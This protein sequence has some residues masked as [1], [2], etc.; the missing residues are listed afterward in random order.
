M[1]DDPAPPSASREDDG[2]I[3]G[4]EDLYRVIFD[5]SP[6]LV[7]VHDLD[8]RFLD[9]NAR[10]LERLGYTR[11]ALG[12]ITFSDILCAE[13]VPRALESARRIIED[14]AVDEIEQ[15]RIRTRDDEEIWVETSG[16]RLLKE[17]KPYAILG[18]AHDITD[19][20]Q[21]EQALRDERDR[22]QQ[23]LDVADVIFIAISIDGD[24][25]M[26]N[27]KGCELLG[28]R[29]EEVVGKN[30]FENFVTQEVRD[31]IIPV[32]RKLQTGDLDAAEYHE[33]TVLTR[34]GEERL[35]AWH[36]TVLRDANGNICAYL[37]SGEDITDRKWAEEMFGIQRDL[38]V[39]LNAV[40]D[41]DKGLRLCL[42]AA[43]QVSEMDC[44]GV[45]L[46]DEATGGLDLACSAGLSP[47]FSEHI[48]HYDAAQ[49]STAIVM[50]GGPVYASYRELNIPMDDPRLREGLRAI[51]VL[52][53]HH[54]GRVIACLNIASHVV[55]EVGERYRTSLE[56]IAGQIGGAIA[57]LR[58]KEALGE[59]ERRYRL[60]FEQSNDAVFVHDTEGR[61]LD[62]NARASEMLGY[63]RQQLL[64]M[65]VQDLHP[66][67]NREKA[68]G[69]LQKV[70]AEG[71]VKFDAAFSRSDGTIIDVEISSSVID[72]SR[73]IVQGIAR[74][75]TD[76]ES[77]RSEI[78][79]LAR[80]TSE[81]PSPVLRVSSDGII[82]HANP[83]SRPL[84]D[85]WRAGTGVR[86]PDCIAASVAESYRG[87]VSL[88]T[89]V[90]AGDRTYSFVLAPVPGEDYVNL[91]GRDITEHKR[92]QEEHLHTQ[93]ME[94]I[95]LLAGGI[96]HDFSNL[97]QGILGYAN[98]LKRQF[99]GEKRVFKA[100]DII[101]K[102]GT[103]AAELTQQLLGFAR[104]GK[105]RDT[106]VDI[107]RAIS[108]TV[109]LLSST[110]DKR[111]ILLQ[112]LNADQCI[113]KGDPGQLQQVIMN[114]A[115]NARDAMPE[116]GELSFET[117]L[118]ELAEGS[119]VLPANAPGGRY[120]RVS[121]NDTGV[122]IAHNVR[123]RVFEPFFTT[124]P[125]GKGT[126]MGLAMVYGIV[127][128]H[129][130]AIEVRSDPG[131]GTTF[132]ILLPLAEKGARAK[133]ARKL[134]VIPHGS[135]CILV[136]DDEEIVRA[137]LREMLTSLG[138][139]VRLA[140]NGRD[141]VELYRERSA[142]I[143]LVL[144]DLTMPVM[145]GRECFDELRKVDPEVKVVI[146]TGHALD[147]MAQDMMETGALR[148][149]H[150]PFLKPE[151]AET[152]AKAL[153]D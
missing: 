92:L 135:G 145:N 64:S 114:L 142:D 4:E 67:H 141:A 89:E 83:A 73:G 148:F 23:Y 57:G 37:S 65:S 8:G 88:E 98:M 66:A 71:H 7:Y 144:L 96:A 150:K 33:N 62:A 70:A 152:I 124:K 5:N 125:L 46:V 107:H 53:V 94:A 14:G 93:K 127:R 123:E 113:V 77:A 101:E 153:A 25:M 118:V 128:N 34:G 35:I 27:R 68:R 133:D 132:D 86:I 121:V 12:A 82:L 134:Q 110:I 55:W 104:R 69:S 54:D 106:P 58:A 13:D 56:T 43:L 30:W 138:Y 120:V 29:E 63:D 75:I 90:E 21:A 18:F 19:R 28:Y 38:A 60:I 50:R 139:D 147:G 10:A 140:S 76:R 91:Y 80:F 129:G 100:A 36:N 6:E 99:M 24:V 9:A 112:W 108:E 131:E 126:G 103:R 149:I 74:D 48:S 78:E 146:A 44:G 111:I 49:P 39:A 137:I 16:V 40:S 97:L 95:G 26:I 47:E 136:V 116:G 61:M 20:K 119:P 102:A 32:A 59:S 109:A 2:D 41:I 45:Y 15:Y 42:E 115:V 87:G 84:L 105:L 52:P 31:E 151:L 81:D 122:G 17:G 130:G 51:A 22:A 3:H 72:A 79:G 1:L 117:D 143:D 85:E 11:E